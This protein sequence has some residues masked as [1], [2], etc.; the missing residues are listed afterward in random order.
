MTTVNSSP[1]R[2]TGPIL[3]RNRVSYQS[4]PRARSPRVRVRYAGHQRDAEEDRDRAGDLGDGHV[5]AGGL[6]AQP[7]GQHL[8]VEEAKRGIQQ[9]LE[10][11]VQRDQ[12]GGHLPVT[13]RQVGPDQH[14]GDAAG[15]ADQDDAGPVGGLVRQQQPGQREHDRRADHP[16]E[17]QRG[18]H[19]APVGG[20]PPDLGVADL[21]EYRVHHQQQPERDRQAGA[22]DR[23]LVQRAVKARD[24]SA[25]QQPGGHRRPDPHR[26]EPV[27]PGQPGHHRPLPGRGRRPRESSCQSPRLPSSSWHG[28]PH[29]FVMIRSP[30]S[31]IP[32]ADAWAHSAANPSPSRR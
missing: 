32:A 10:D 16:V 7:A 13:A 3:G 28:D 8:Q 21:R 11:R 19:H 14:H 15:Q 17:H 18:G 9:D 4:R 24:Q 25:Q 26:Q 23:D 1:Y 29:R 6:Q 5:Q 2:A 12:H 31:G 22:V 30:G 27:Q 20:D